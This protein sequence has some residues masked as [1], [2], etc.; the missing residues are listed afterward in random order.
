MLRTRARLFCLTFALTPTLSTPL[1]HAQ[2]QA[3]STTAR[4]SLP[5]DS[6]VLAIIRQRVDEKRSPG[7]VVGLVDGAGRTRVVA[8]GDP[9]PGRPPLDGNSVFEIGSITKVFT[10]T[11]LADMVRKGE[12]KL[13][14]AVQSFLPA[15]V[16]VPTRNGKAITLAHLAQQN[17]GL[18][19]LPS[20]FQP[21]NA[22]NPYADYT[23]QQLY[24]FLSSCEY[25]WR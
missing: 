12:V 15:S 23:V 3:G 24:D 5:S 6:A 25:R 9:G 4:A 10:G 20:N 18:P 14:D 22:T 19:R 21:T 7:I 17:S 11:V 13:D 1:A 16:R 2:Q 8:Y